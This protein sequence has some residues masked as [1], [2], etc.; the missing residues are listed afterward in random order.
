MRIEEDYIYVLHRHIVKPYVTP[1]M[2]VGVGVVVIVV[3]VVVVVVV[4][5]GGGGGGETRE[6]QVKENRMMRSR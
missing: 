6:G 5:A 4:G 1:D 2:T 3:V